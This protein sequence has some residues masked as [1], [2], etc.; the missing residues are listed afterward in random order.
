MHRSVG[1]IE[2]ETIYLSCSFGIARR[3]ALC[4]LMRGVQRPLPIRVD[5][6]PFLIK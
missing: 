6:L 1:K 5:L 3:G 2:E 4:Q